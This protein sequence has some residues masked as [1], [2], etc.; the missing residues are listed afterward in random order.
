MPAAS[1]LNSELAVV[2]LL[3][4]TDPIWGYFSWGLD[5][6]RS[7]IGVGGRIDYF[8]LVGS[9]TSHASLICMY[10]CMY[11]VVEHLYSILHLKAVENG[12]LMLC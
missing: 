11:D 1:P 12:F 9:G 7:G 10:V 4:P 6:S 3:C 5:R 8:F 2:P